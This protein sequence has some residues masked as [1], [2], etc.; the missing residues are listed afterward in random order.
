MLLFAFCV[1]LPQA[2]AATADDEFTREFPLA[3]CWFASVGGN[4]YFPII[5]GR[6]TYFTNQDCVAAGRCDEL[7][8]LWITVE[9]ETRTIRIPVGR[10]SKTLRARVME[11]RETADGE[12]VEISRNYL[13]GCLPSND[14]Y[15]FGEDV[16]IYEDGEVVSHDGAWLAGRDGARPGILMPEDGFL[17]GSRYYQEVAPGIAL[18]R[19]EHRRAWFSVR[20]PAGKF[21]DCIA[22]EETT[23]LEP[24]SV[25]KKTYCRGVGM[26]RDGDLE[27]TA[28]YSGRH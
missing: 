19:A 10:G 28:I 14:V 27:L 5:P 1:A 8:E 12:L 11:E 2:R 26:V 20:V 16:D 9:R 17:I 24:G 22:V 15:Y 25:S 21:D 7:E 4:A 18:D 3:S 6:Q 13:A 23:P